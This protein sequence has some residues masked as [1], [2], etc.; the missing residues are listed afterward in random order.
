MVN[1]E[2]LRLVE[3]IQAMA[4]REN[5][6]QGIDKILDN[7]EVISNSRGELTINNKELLPALNEA[8]NSPNELV[9][10]L[11][12]HI[13]GELRHQAEPLLPQ[14]L[15]LLED[16]SRGVKVN[17]M[18]VIAGFGEKSKA[19]IP[20]LLE[21][22]DTADNLMRVQAMENIPRIDGSKLECMV[23]ML[24]AASKQDS[25]GQV[26]AINAL[27]EFQAAAAIPVLKELTR[28]SMAMTR[29]TAAEAI[30]Q[31]TG[32][33]SDLIRI[34]MDMLEAQDSYAQLIAKDCIEKWQRQR[35]VDFQNCLA[36]VIANK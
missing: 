7:L 19:A 27:G 22:C 29:L 25:I 35:P 12:V 28:N 5:W 20:I 10:E 4:H 33:L 1:K 2:R 36:E 15:R 8:L 6:L 23:K 11:A 21:W 34:S 16:P 13:A 31:I 26:T 24:I 17:A 18:F 32:N 3:I 30:Y 14:L 9:R